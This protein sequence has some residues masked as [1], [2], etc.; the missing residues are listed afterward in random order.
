MKNSILFLLAILL[1]PALSAQVT[2]IGFRPMVTLSTYKLAGD[3]GDTYDAA[4][5]PG[6]GFAGFVEV[7]LGNRFTV[8][9]EIAFV[10]RGAS[11]NSESTLTWPGSDFGYPDEYTV[12]DYRLRETLNYLDIAAMFERNFGGGN[13]GAYLA[14]GPALSF[15]LGNGK[16]IEQITADAE[17]GSGSTDRYEYSIEMGKGRNDVYSG[18]DLSLNVGGGLI[19]I[20]E[21]GELGLDLRYSHGLRALD[22]EGLKN[23]SFQIGVSYMHYLG[24]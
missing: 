8:Q 9:P 5:R 1:A 15:G 24:D 10:Q 2:G 6:G 12:T 4:L 3:L 11:L 22:T 21:R 19:Y 14:A 17:D 13:F 23:R 20:M 18:V 7:N 16:G